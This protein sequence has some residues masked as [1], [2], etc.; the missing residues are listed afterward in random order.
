[1]SPTTKSRAVGAAIAL[2][3]LG[4]LAQAQ[5]GAIELFAGE[6]IFVE[7][8]RVSLTQL[9]QYKDGLLSGS[10]SVADPDDR[11]F[12]ES[13]T[14]LGV[15]H[16]IARGW[17]VSALLPFVSREAR[18]V[19]GT[20][21]SSG[22]GDLAVVLKNSFYRVD[23]DRSAWHTAWLAGVEAPTGVTDEREGGV[24]L[25]PSMQ[26]G[27]GSWD[28]FVGLASTLD[29]DLWRFDAVALYEDDGE[30]SQ[31]HD[32]GER[33]RLSLSGKYRWLHEVYPGPTASS[34]VGLE[35]SHQARARSG[36]ALVGDS[37]GDA[38][39]LKLSTGWHPRPDLDLG[40]SLKLPLYEDV[41][42]TQ[43]GLDSAVQLSLGWRF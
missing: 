36:G 6:T 25:A 5:D 33:L 39:L 24:R 4:G 18:S 13:R 17:S 32:P 8:T 37:G 14:V 2:T 20:D 21:R 9:F 12:Q 31:D 3:C 41:N 34:T 11:R 30:G 19:A 15:N 7:G 29:L 42:G 35:W 38:L 27:S 40:I 16:G 1:M 10:D 28:P 22:V 26:P 43:L 23:W